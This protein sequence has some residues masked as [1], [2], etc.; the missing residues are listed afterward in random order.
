MDYNLVGGLNPSEKY[1]SNGIIVPNIWKVI[2]NVPNHQPGTYSTMWGLPVTSW[3][4]SPSNYS[5]LR[6]INHSYWSNLHNLAIKRGPHILPLLSK[7]LLCDTSL[8]G[9]G[10]WLIYGYIRYWKKKEL[11]IN[12]S[13][14]KK[15]EHRW[16]LYW[17]VVEP[18]LWKIWVNWG[19]YSQ[20]MEK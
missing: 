16:N 17:L 14:T 6:T 19:Y 9:F 4:I 12:H 8:N 7:C 1:E 5:Y 13:A 18:P 15:M 11:G 10:E 2:K 3:F 20:Y